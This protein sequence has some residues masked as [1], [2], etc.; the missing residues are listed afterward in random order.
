MIRIKS[1]RKI[2]YG[3]QYGNEFQS[4]RKADIMT[5]KNSVKTEYLGG[6]ISVMCSE[7]HRF[8]TDAVVLEYFAAAKLKMR[9]KI[10]KIID[11]GT[12]CGIIPMLF[13]RDTAENAANVKIYA[14]DIQPDA[15]KL[16]ETAVEENQLSGRVVPI[17]CDLNEICERDKSLCG[18]FD[19]VTMNPPYK[20]KDSGLMT[21]NE[22]LNIARFELKCDFDGI[23]AAAARLLKH[24]GSFFVCNRPSRLADMICAMRKH[25]IEPKREQCVIQ[26]MGSAPQ[27][28]LLEGILGANADMD[29]LPPLYLEDENGKLT[30]DAEKIYAKWEYDRK[31]SSR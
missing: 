31:N 10:E 26:R 2:Q 5:E 11:L 7:T 22:G 1:T 20:R 18:S 3:I 29:I 9:R 16:V 17:C 6:N 24:G 8:G 30:S 21:E 27:L 28:V 4:D 19:I 13:A 15:V 12:G 25:G 23:C 14:L